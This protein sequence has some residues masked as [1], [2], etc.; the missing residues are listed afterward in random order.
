M[1]EG[2]AIIISSLIAVVG[3]IVTQ[4]IDYLNRKKDSNER[5][6]YEIYQRRL[7]LYDDVS[8]ILADMGRP[9]EQLMNMS[10]K[11]FGT[12]LIGDNHTLLSLICQLNI[13]GS[14]DVKKTLNASIVKIR[15]IMNNTL[16]IQIANF[17]DGEIL[18]DAV[19][20]TFFIKS[21][22]DFVTLVQDSL[23]EFAEYVRKETGANF[24]DKKIIK[25]LKKFTKEKI[26][27]KPSGDR[28]T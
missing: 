8:R 6:F 17:S 1:T 16:L 28:N 19:S 20:S 2:T 27:K 5:F 26:D 7:A 4:L 24:V 12:K 14:P 21:V 13:Y 10:V 22:S 9:S 18:R 25:F 3:I 23:T 11:E 15:D